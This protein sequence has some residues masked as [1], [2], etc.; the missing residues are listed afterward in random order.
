MSMD[1]LKKELKENNIRN[2]YLFYGPEEYL[3]KYYIDTITQQL[4]SSDDMEL[5]YSCTD[6]KIE[7]DSVIQNCETLPVFCEK[8]V[9]IVKNSGLFKS[10]GKG[11]KGKL[12]EYLTSIPEY[13]CLIFVENEVDKRLKLVNSI[14][15]SGMVVEFAYQ[16]PADL[17]KWVIKVVKSYKKDIVPLAASYIVE[18]SEYSMTELLNEINKLIVFAADKKDI[19]LD[20]AMSK[21]AKKIIVMLHYPPTNEGAFSS[22]FIDLIMQYPVSHVIYGHLHDKHGW[23]KNIKGKVGNIIYS[24]VS[25]DYLEFM[26]I[27]IDA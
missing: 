4:L 11:A 16:K 27:E 6:G 17:V 1:I 18:N 20:D 24:L 25:A 26:P 2:V 8:K 22:A 5:N 21:Q 12:E 23:G 3:K 10:E 9:I 14:K 13:T 15:K 7:A 19:S